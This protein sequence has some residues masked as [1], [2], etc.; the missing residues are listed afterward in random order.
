M[1][2]RRV[3]LCHWNSG[4]AGEL[5]D[6]L[7][8]AGFDTLVA[9]AP[10]EA[11]DLLRRKLPD[12]LV[13][14]LLRAPASGRDMALYLRKTTFTRRVP[15]VFIEG[16]PVKT[17][18]VRRLLPDALFTTP[19]QL[20]RAVERALVQAPRDPVVPASV[21]AGYAGTPLPKKLGIREGSRVILAG[22]PAGFEET[23]GRLPRGVTLRRRARPPC[24]LVIWFSRQRAEVERRIE[25][26]G[27]LAGR[28]GLWVSWPKKASGVKSDLTQ[29]VVREIGLAAGL[30]DYKVCSIDSTWSGLRFTRRKDRGGGR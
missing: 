2:N 23:L 8:E 28:D 13:I 3:H 9:T 25:S 17:D 22:A 27:E 21:F 12:A 29:A 26:M 1:P 11:M 5:A 20:D 16:D 18:Q 24:D 7:R 19:E 6:Q 15:L 14:S 10:A 4:E 30:V